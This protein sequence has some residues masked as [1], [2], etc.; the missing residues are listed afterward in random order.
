MQGGGGRAGVHRQVHARPVH[1]AV[2]LLLCPAEILQPEAQDGVP[3][4][5]RLFGRMMRTAGNDFL[6][7]GCRRP[8]CRHQA[9]P[10]K[11]IHMEQGVRQ[12]EKIGDTYVIRSK[13]FGDTYVIR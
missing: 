3:G 7:Q 5:R 11:G 12:P 13:N 4:G 10:P 1:R 2:G 6:A 8:Q 9:W